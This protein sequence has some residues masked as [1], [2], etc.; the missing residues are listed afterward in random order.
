MTPAQRERQNDGQGPGRGRTAQA[1][2]SR[3]GG[4][5]R[6]G[7]R[8]PRVPGSQVTKPNSGGVPLQTEAPKQQSFKTP[9]EAIK[10]IQKGLVNVGD[11][12][13]LN[14]VPVVVQQE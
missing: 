6:P 8:A 12:I 3:S 10:A 11:T 1:P 4:D 5:V 13:I 2:G 7:A 14:G 9:D